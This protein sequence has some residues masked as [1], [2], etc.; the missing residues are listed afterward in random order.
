MRGLALDLRPDH[1]AVQP[2]FFGPLFGSR[3]QFASDTR[4]SKTARH[5]KTADLGRRVGLQVGDDSHVDPRHHAAIDAA[6]EYRMASRI[7]Q[8]PNAFRHGGRFNGIAEFRAKARGRFR[9]RET[10]FANR[11]ASI[12]RRWPSSVA[13]P[14]SSAS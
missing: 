3:Q 10:D 6:D 14:G 4:A 7:G 13:V 9:I 1:H 5:H 8:A 12:I 11:Q 2:A